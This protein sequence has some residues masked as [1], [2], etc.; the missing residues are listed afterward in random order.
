MTPPRAAPKMRAMLIETE[1]R[2]T[3]LRKSAGET[4]SEMNA[5]RVGLSNTLTHPS[6]SART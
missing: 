1:F 4:I 3:A 5:C 2:V 6:I